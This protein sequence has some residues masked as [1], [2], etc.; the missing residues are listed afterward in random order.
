M[1][2]SF[3]FFWLYTL[4]NWLFC[5]VVIGAFVGFGLVG[6]LLVRLFLLRLFGDKG[7]NDIVG[8]YLSASGVF[9][10]VTLGDPVSNPHPIDGDFLIEEQIMPDYE[11]VITD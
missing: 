4:P 9:F 3:N 7:H 5:A 10:G 2:A 8:Q 1:F 6:Q 11:N